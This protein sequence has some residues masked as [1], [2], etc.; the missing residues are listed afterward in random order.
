M[1]YKNS[2]TKRMFDYL[3]FHNTISNYKLEF[4]SNINVQ[5]SN[6]ELQ[7]NVHNSSDFHLL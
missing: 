2:V 1:E 6:I 5:T 7:K 3:T 4:S